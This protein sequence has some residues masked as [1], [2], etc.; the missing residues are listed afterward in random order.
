MATKNFTTLT[1]KECL[2]AAEGV[3]ENSEKKWEISTLLAANGKYGEAST[4]AMV[5]IEEMVKSII[6]LIDARGFRLRKIKGMSMMFRNHKIR[7]L[8]AYM[9]FVVD[10]V[11]QELKKLMIDI[12]EGRVD[13]NELM[14]KLEKKDS[15]FVKKINQ[16]GL[17]KFRSLR[18]EFVWFSKA[19]IFRQEGLYCDFIDKFKSPI[20]VSETEYIEVIK[21]LSQVRLVGQ[22]L[23]ATLNST[24]NIYVEYLE[25]LKKRFIHDKYYKKIE[26]SFDSLKK[27]RDDP[28]EHLKKFLRG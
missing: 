23:I 16:Y 24:E 8:I 18:Q 28:F 6:L 11:S 22:G 5:S 9:M 2:L 7:Y 25:T 14:E 15:H 3:L 19:E 26:L 13:A 17:M 27:T 21:R 4:M 1:T 10:V 12:M 20:K